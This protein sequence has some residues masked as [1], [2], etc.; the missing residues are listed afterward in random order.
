M[1][2]RAK[3]VISYYKLKNKKKTIREKRYNDNNKSVETSTFEVKNDLISNSDYKQINNDNDISNTIKVVYT[4][5][6]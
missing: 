3:Y 2:F 1:E 4:T 5:S 6:T